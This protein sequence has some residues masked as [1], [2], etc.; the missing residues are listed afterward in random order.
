MLKSIGM[1]RIPGVIVP[2]V[3]SV[4]LSRYAIICSAAGLDTWVPCFEMFVLKMVV[5]CRRWVWEA[6][7]CTATEADTF[8]CCASDI[9]VTDVLGLK[10]VPVTA[11]EIFTRCKAIQAKLVTVTEFAQRPQSTQLLLL[12]QTPPATPGTAVVTMF[13][14]RMEWTGPLSRF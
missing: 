8:T 11:Y 13:L 7:R 10:H 2:Q 1:D 12:T 4:Q 3:C 14:Q 5:S 9:L 6:S